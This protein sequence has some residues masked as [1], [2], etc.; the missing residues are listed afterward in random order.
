MTL[1][2]MTPNPSW[3]P[4]GYEDAV[5]TFAALADEITVHVWGG[6]WC[7][8]CRRTLPDFAAVLE[9]AG[10]PGGAI[11]TYPVEKLDDGS[12]VGPEVEA[13]GVEY[14]PTIV[15]EREGVEIARFV[16]EESE[17]PAVY[18]AEQLR[19]RVTKQ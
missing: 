10:V 5:E 18:L 17:P 4:D 11:E 12:K 3:E 7:G 1:E 8:D 19:E 9:A 2:T 15:I 6:D 13:Y 14:I 16:E